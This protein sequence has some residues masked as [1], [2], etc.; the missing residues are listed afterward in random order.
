[1]K[2]IKNNPLLILAALM[3]ILWLSTITFGLNT[4]SR[5][6]TVR[7]LKIENKGLKEDNEMLIRFNQDLGEQLNK[8][9]QEDR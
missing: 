7:R 1:M 5:D 2:K 6:K 4:V 3:F 9:I 8:K